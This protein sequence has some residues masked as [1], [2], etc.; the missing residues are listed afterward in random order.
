MTKGK[1]VGLSVS[2]VV[3]ICV[4][5]VA[6]AAAGTAG[7][8][9]RLDEY[10][11]SAVDQHQPMTDVQAKVTSEGFEIH[12][13]TGGFTAVGPS[14]MAVIYKSWLTLDVKSGPDG[15]CHGYHLDHAGELF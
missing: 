1:I 15:L 12:P 9:K 4:V 2:G 11:K 13:S 14:R 8:A 3:L 7:Q 6:L 10:L 5:W